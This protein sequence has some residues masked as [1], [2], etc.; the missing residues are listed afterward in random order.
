MTFG[1]IYY[2]DIISHAGSIRSVIVITEYA[3]LFQLANSNLCDVWHKVVRDTIWVLADGSALVGTDRIKITKQHYVPLRICFLDV[4]KNLLQH[5]F[6]PAI[7]IGTLS[8][9]T[10]FCD[11]DLCRISIYSCRGRENNIL[12]TMFSHYIYKSQGSCNI[13]LIIFPRLYNGLSN[14]LQS[15]KMNT[16]VNVFFVKN[17]VKGFPV[18]DICFIKF[19]RLA[20]DLG[21]SVKGLL[22]GIRQII[23]NYYVITGILKFYNCMASNVSCTACY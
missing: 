22:A 11:R 6:G 8:F 14:S 21:N 23:Q 19:N 20:C 7:W 9:R 12:N 3:K 17:L 16:G 15:G 13:I 10:F 18:Q 2:M 4:C 1:K 5:G